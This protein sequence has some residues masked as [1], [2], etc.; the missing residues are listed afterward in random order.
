MIITVRVRSV[1]LFFLVWITD[2]VADDVG[3]EG[4]DITG[5]ASQSLSI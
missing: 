1:V 5:S 4:D 3:G 2:T